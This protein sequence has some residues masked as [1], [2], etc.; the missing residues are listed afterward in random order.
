M[1]SFDQNAFVDNVGVRAEVVARCD[2]DLVK[3][4][5]HKEWRLQAT[6]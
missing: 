6:E 3:A 2:V 1:D 5:S 4:Y